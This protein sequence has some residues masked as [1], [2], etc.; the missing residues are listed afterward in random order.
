MK[1]YGTVYLSIAYLLALLSV[2]CVATA[3]SEPWKKDLKR[4]LSLLGSQNWIIIAEPAYPHSSGQH[5]QSMVV[6][7]S[8]PE[9]LHEVL[10]TMEELGHVTPRIHLTREVSQL[11]E[12]Y[13]PGIIQHREQLKEVIESRDIIELPNNALTLSLREA[14]NHYKILLLKTPTTLPYSS[15]F[16]ELDSGYWDGDS[17]TQLRQTHY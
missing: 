15:V 3:P 7:G 13:A 11:T 8:I 5:V 12:D 16:I 10:L 17:E 2:G 4:E 14:Q 6:E 9:V 1:R